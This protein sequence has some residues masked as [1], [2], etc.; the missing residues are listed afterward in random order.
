MKLYIGNKTYSSW[1]MRPWVLMRACGIAFDE[2]FV[3]FDGFE[4]HHEFKKKMT[5]LHAAATV[6][7]L[8][9]EGL[10][11]GDSLA[12]MEYLAERFPEAAVWPDDQKARAKARLV[13]A[14]MHS[15]FGAL[16]SHCLMNIGADL[17][18]V[19]A[20]LYA[21]HQALRDDVERL[22]SLL[23]PHLEVQKQGSFLFGA[24]CA[25]DAFYAPV[26]TRIQ[27]YGLPIS[28][29]LSNYQDAVLAHEAV[30]AWVEAALA[31]NIFLEFEEPYRSAP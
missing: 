6:P 25:A 29:R 9:A 28:K 8:D 7:L 18:A 27:T 4:A 20:K 22:E 15:G 14:V 11:I 23:V 16:R 2:I 10:L 1:S 5:E 17:T 12:I 30:T 31:E 24:F 26:M 21:E 19:G 3:P 13:S